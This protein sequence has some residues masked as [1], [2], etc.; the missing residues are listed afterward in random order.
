MADDGGLGLEVV[1]AL[2]P[3]PPDAAVVL[4][5]S[6]VE[7]PEGC[8]GHRFR[9]DR[10]LAAKHREH[11]VMAHDVKVPSDDGALVLVLDQNL[12]DLT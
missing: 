2:L 9:G 6:Q 3:S 11:D 5:L 7:G 1:G 4:R 12:V 8:R 10:F